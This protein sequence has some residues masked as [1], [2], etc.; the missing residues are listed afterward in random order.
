M[1]EAK[2]K[3]TPELVGQALVY[4]QFALDA[5]AKVQESFVF[6]ET[7]EDSMLV[8]IK[9]LGLAAEVLGGSA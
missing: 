8:A 4:R 5:G 3:L 9:E 2:T 6:A 1:C 7:G